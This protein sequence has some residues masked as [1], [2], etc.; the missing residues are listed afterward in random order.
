MFS[1]IYSLF[2][3]SKGNKDVSD[4]IQNT[5]KELIK[6]KNEKNVAE[7]NESVDPSISYLARDD[8]YMQA[9]K[10]VND[11]SPCRLTPQLRRTHGVYYLEI[12][13]VS[14]IDGRSY[15]L[16]FWPCTECACIKIIRGSR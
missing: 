6:I 3:S 9:S 4:I 12:A 13:V 2:K 16:A 14:D 7:V 8:V 5:I 11:L 1:Y 15:L 10:L